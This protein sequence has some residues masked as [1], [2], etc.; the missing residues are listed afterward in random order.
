[1]NFNTL[2]GSAKMYK[3][4]AVCATGQITAPGEVPNIAILCAVDRFENQKLIDCV[5]TG[6]KLKGGIVTIID[7]PA[8]GYINKI[9][10]MTA[11]YASSFARTS[12][13]TAEAII[14][15]GL[16]D[17]VVIIANCDTTAAG[18][19]E[20]AAKANCPALI[21]TA[22][23]CFGATQSINDYRIQGMV[24]SGMLN[25]GDGE[26]RIQNAM[27]FRGV[28]YNFNSVSTFFILME[29]MGFCVPNASTSRIES[30]PHFRNAMT[31]GERICESAKGVLSPKKFLTRENLGNAIALSLSIGGDISGI[32]AITNLVR[33]YD[34]KISHGIIAEYASKAV[35]LVA[36]ENQHCG[37]I[38]EIGGATSILKQLSVTSKLIDDSA[39][40]YT[41]EK[42]KGLLA[43]AK[44]TELTELSKTAMVVLAKGTACED[45]GYSQTTPKT[46]I[47]ISGKA[48]VY[49]SLEEADKALAQ[50]SVPDNSVVVV[51]NCLDTSVSALAYTIEGM[52]KQ[53]KIAIITDGFCDKTTVLVVTRC[54]PNS[55]ANE[56]FANIQNGDQLEIDL[57][58]GRLNTNVMA[59]EQKNRE[60]RNLT[61]KPTTYFN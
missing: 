39:L 14:K 21:I 13:S 2:S 11:K 57:G 52:E 51:H 5:A 34:T 7:V 25:S 45:G 44:A 12:A 60:K 17:G 6:A 54:S 47:S 40:A 18:L 53:S 10:P 32:Q 19:L 22:G 56:A 24:T 49:S 48:W 29:V 36:P 9:N 46:P 8:F 37:Y 4:M 50:G 30:A 42:L 20:G 15:C 33:V 55:L 41:G 35:L 23:A 26:T 1:M 43:D 3:K 61:R 16:Y 28:S 27:V 58:R 38:A 31:T 59:K